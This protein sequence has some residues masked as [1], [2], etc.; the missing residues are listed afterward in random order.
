[1]NSQIFETAQQT[2]SYSFILTAK[3]RPTHVELGIKIST[4]SNRKLTSKKDKQTDK[5]IKKEIKKQANEESDSLRQLKSHSV[6][7]TVIHL[8]IHSLSQAYSYR[9]WRVKQIVTSSV[10]QTVRQNSY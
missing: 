7:K 1:M 8:I 9:H 3:N 4:Q 2:I 5:E 6:K 10:K